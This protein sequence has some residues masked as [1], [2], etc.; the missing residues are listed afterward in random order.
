[1]LTVESVR[2]NGQQALKPL[3]QE[4]KPMFLQ[5]MLRYTQDYDHRL[6]AFHEAMIAFYEY[7]IYG[8]YDPSKSAPKTLIINMGR[9]YLINRLKKESKSSYQDKDE[10]ELSLNKLMK[11]QMEFKLD[12]N[13]FKIKEA[14]LQLGDKCKELLLMFYYH[15]YGVEVI[16]ER[17]Q[18]KNE[19]VVS[20]H[21]SR[22]IKKLKELL[23][24]N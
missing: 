21:K 17:M 19:N 15:N 22:C 9:A 13:E 10:M 16:K 20:S 5:Y 14:L 18:Y 6:D 1:M 8:K 4:L 24:I 11:N 12:D 2:Q 3:Y 23:K 7:C